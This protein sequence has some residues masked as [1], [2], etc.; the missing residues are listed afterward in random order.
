MPFVLCGYLG[1]TAPCMAAFG[2]WL[3]FGARGDERHG[4]G[5]SSKS[6]IVLWWSFAARIHGTFLGRIRKK[7]QLL[8]FQ[9]PVWRL[10][11]LRFV[12]R[13]C[14]CVDVWISEPM[15]QIIGVN[16]IKHV[17]LRDEAFMPVGGRL[18]LLST[19]LKE[20]HPKMSD[21]KIQIFNCARSLPDSPPTF[22]TTK[23]V[24]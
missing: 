17:I 2:Q 6:G 1:W 11:G 21:G 20:N 19:T 22:V 8:R 5:Q 3:G 18:S 9:L 16:L 12:I 4:T 13:L 15:K 14:W 23:R 7:M 24:T 10:L